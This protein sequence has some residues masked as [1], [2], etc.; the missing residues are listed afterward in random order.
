MKDSIQ[1]ETLEK[2]L[3]DNPELEKLEGLLS[4]FN[5]FE[6]LRMVNTEIRHSNVLAWLLTPS[7]NHGLGDYFLKQFLRNFVV[8]N[9]SALEKHIS[10]FDLEILTYS[11][12]EVRREWKNIDILLLIDEDSHMIFPR[13]CGHTGELGRIMIITGSWDK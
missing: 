4:Q 6:T 9:K 7:E 10:L 5:V 3:L 12:V 1:I 2:F 11:N 13:Y 8:E